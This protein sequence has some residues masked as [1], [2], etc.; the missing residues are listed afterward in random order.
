M[1]TINYYQH[2]PETCRYIEIKP[3]RDFFG[4]VDCVVV[5][6]FSFRILIGFLKIW[7]PC[8]IGLYLHVIQFISS[9]KNK[10]MSYIILSRMHY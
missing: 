2:H 7:T 6:L 3:K 9:E 4:L 10:V 8:P 1:R 5:D